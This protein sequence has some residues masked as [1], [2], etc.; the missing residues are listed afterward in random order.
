MILI[1]N[2]FGKYSKN[3]F[4]MQVFISIIFFLHFLFSFKIFFRKKNIF[5]HFDFFFFN[6]FEIRFN[7]FLIRYFLN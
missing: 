3:D 1:V 4:E 7:I 5:I 6:L 2:Y